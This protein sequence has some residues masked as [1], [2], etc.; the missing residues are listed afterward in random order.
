MGVG[1]GGA[2]DEV[3]SVVEVEV[4][5]DV[6]GGTEGAGSTIGDGDETGAMVTDVEAG[7]GATAVGP[8]TPACIGDAPV[9]VTELAVVGVTW[10]LL[11]PRLAV[12]ALAAA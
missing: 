10:G 12:R 8:T 4:E 3:T 2:V 11:G 5:V 7:D 6:E 1:V 9:R